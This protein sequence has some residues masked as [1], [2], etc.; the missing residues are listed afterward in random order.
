MEKIKN[1]QAFSVIVAEAPYNVL[2]RIMTGIGLSTLPAA[3]NSVKTAIAVATIPQVFGHAIPCLS[4]TKVA[5]VLGLST[6]FSLSVF[7]RA[8]NPIPIAAS[9]IAIL[10]FIYIL[11]DDLRYTKPASKVSTNFDLKRK[12]ESQPLY[13]EVI[14][15]TKNFSHHLNTRLKRRTRLCSI[16]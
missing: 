6:K 10:Y 11:I 15:W 9:L 16:F 13:E 3:V 12:K 4:G 2:P 14:L 5:D 1:K 7:L 8:L